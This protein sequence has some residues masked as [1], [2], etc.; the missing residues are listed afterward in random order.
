VV[1]L[2]ASKP[3]ITTIA[4]NGTHGFSGDGSSAT[5]GELSRPAGLA[6]NAFG[7]LFV[8][9]TMNGRVREV[10]KAG[11]ISTVAGNG[12]GSYP[13]DNAAAT[14]AE[15]TSPLGVAMDSAGNLYI[16][17]E[18]ANRVRKV[19]ASGII[20]TVAGNG[21]LGFT[22][23]TGPATS[24]EMRAPF[25]VAVDGAGNLYIAEGASQRIRKVSAATGII[26]TVA[27]NG[28]PGYAGDNG[29]ATVAEL[30]N[31]NGV[32]T[33]GGGNLYIADATNNTVRKVTPA[34]TITTVAGN[35]TAGFSGDGGAATSAALHD[36][37]GVLVDSAGNLYIAD[38]TNRRV[39]KVDT[40]G[41]ITTVAGNGMTGF[42]GD[43][44][45]AL[46]AAIAPFAIAVETAGNLY[47]GDGG[48]S[49]VRKVTY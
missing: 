13:G 37:A 42:A 6:V 48:S 36:P 26:T 8:A 2:S 35:G 15:L 18:F 27:G 10:N 17:D 25:D 30:N 29:P 38:S 20:V 32:A 5:L 31:P 28:T 49:R 12:M 40:A 11:T 1:A 19:N 47:I 3:L 4:G 21:A 16:A 34:G 44:G 43:G 41:I 24:A 9:D 46:S 39:R 45:D 7:Q 23:D 14:S 22:G 33:D